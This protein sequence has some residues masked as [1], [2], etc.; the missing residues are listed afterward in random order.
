MKVF[1]VLSNDKVIVK[2]S[3]VTF[4]SVGAELAGFF[5]FMYG[6][7]YLVFGIAM[8]CLAQNYFVKRVFY[9]THQPM[10]DDKDVGQKVERRF[11]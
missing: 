5:V 7:M 6:L 10:V 2:E 3:L 11:E 1:L 4:A 8:N 9:V